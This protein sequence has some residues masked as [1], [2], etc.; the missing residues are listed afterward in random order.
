METVRNYKCPN[1]GAPL[2]FGADS[3]KLHCDS[4]GNDFDIELMN[5]L[6]D[7]EKNAGSSKYDWTHYEP[8]NFD[9]AEAAGLAKYN[10]PNCGAEITGDETLGATV[11]P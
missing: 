10:C 7:E 8:R 11:C 2:V 6:D 9:E 5:S 4:C 1:C 3:G